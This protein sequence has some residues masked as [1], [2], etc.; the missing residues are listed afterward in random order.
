MYIHPCI[1][2]HRNYI[3]KY[4]ALHTYIYLVEVAILWDVL[5]MCLTEYN[6]SSLLK[7]LMVCTNQW[8]IYINV[9]VLYIHK[10]NLFKTKYSCTYEYMTHSNTCGVL[11]RAPTN[12]I[13]FFRTSS[14]VASLINFLDS[15]YRTFDENCTW[16][17]ALCCTFAA[18][19]ALVSRHSSSSWY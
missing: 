10:Y 4:T 16:E 17:W 8:S 15:R 7:L 19:L 5:F 14:W 6:R 11:L 1:C 9:H 12:L 18:F 3:L 13:L 2:R